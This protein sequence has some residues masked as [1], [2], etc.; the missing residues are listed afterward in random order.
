MTE[1]V[2]TW[3]TKT[4]RKNS[5]I[6]QNEC[7]F[8]WHSV[9]KYNPLYD[10]LLF[11][12]D[13]KGLTVC[14]R[15]AWRKKKKILLSCDGLC[16]ALTN[17][18]PG[19][20]ISVN[21]RKWISAREETTGARTAPTA[22]GC[23]TSSKGAWCAR[24]PPF[25]PHFSA[26]RAAAR[27]VGR[28][29]RQERPLCCADLLCVCVCLC[30]WARVFVACIYVWFAREPAKSKTKQASASQRET[31]AGRQRGSPRALC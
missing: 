7:Y 25:Y 30:V 2:H 3:I 4:E 6:I 18:S 5:A 29:R 26:A 31:Q 12:A 16:A 15:P 20:L 17:R 1:K 23:R 27:S 21:F 14:Q 24:P 22:R 19:P 28:W 13:S 10:F 9:N 11:H 8:L